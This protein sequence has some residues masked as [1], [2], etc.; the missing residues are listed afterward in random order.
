MMKKIL[1]VLLTALVLFAGCDDDTITGGDDGGVVVSRDGSSSAKAI[2]L[3]ANV[4]ANGNIPASGGEQW[5]K[6]TATAVIQYIHAHFGT[7]NDLYVQLYTSD[8]ATMS[9]SQ[10]RLYNTTKYTSQYLTIGQVYYIKITPYSSTDSGTYQILFNTSSTSPA[11]LPSNIIQLTVNLWVEGN[12]PA[13]GGEQWFKFTATAETQYIHADFGTLTDLYVQLYNIG[14]NTVGSRTNLWSNTKYISQ[15]PL[16]VNQEYYIKVTPYGIGKG[17]YQIAFNESTTAPTAIK[18]PSNAITLTASVLADGN[19]SE[20]DNVQWFKFTATAATQ[21]IHVIF[22]T[23]NDLYVQLYDSDGYTVGNRTELYSST[24]YTSRSV[25]TGEE[26]YI[27]VTP[28]SS[29]YSGTYQIA[30]NTMSIIPVNVTILTAGVWA[31]G[32][33]LTSN[34]EQWFKFTATVDTQYI[35]VIF[36][37]LNDLYVQLYD[38]DGYTVGSR[39]ELYS[40]TKYASRSV[41]TGQEYYIKVTPYSSLIG[42]YQIAFNTSSTPPSL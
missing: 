12:I 33:I 35:H 18:L 39:T 27:K 16:T 8:G 23:L 41:N 36:G 14:G 30:F 15:T 40:S 24:R 3:N 13:S 17:T 2:I 37:T 20:E 32:N 29:Y 25:S 38:S 28:Y 31:D 9:G 5:F 42:T 1:I 6:F 7:L 26:Y 19:I 21:Y 10:T 11:I 4:W 34:A 22:G